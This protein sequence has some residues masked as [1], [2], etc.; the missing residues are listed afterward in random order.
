MKYLINFKERN[1]ALGKVIETPLVA[2]VSGVDGKVC[3]ASFEEFGETV[4]IVE[5]DEDFIQGYKPNIETVTVQELIDKGYARTI[6]QNDS[7]YAIEILD[8]CPYNI[9]EIS[10]FDEILTNSKQVSDAVGG[11]NTFIWRNLPEGWS[12]NDIADKYNNNTIM[13]KPLGGI[14][15]VDGDGPDFSSIDDM[16]V[17]FG[18]GADYQLIYAYPWGGFPNTRGR[19]LFGGT[20][21][22]SPKKFTASFEKGVSS[23]AQRLFQYMM[24]TEELTIDVKPGAVI[25]CHDF[26]GCFEGCNS[27]KKININ[28]EWRWNMNSTDRRASYYYMF[29]GCSKLVEIPLSNLSDDREYSCNMIT[30]IHNGDRGTNF[31]TETFEGCDS[32]KSIKPTIDATELITTDSVSFYTPLLEDVHFKGLNN[33]SWSF[34][35]SKTY[36]PNMN[37]ESIEYLL[38][39]IGDCGDNNYTV[40]FSSLH[41][42]EVSVD[43]INNAK[44]K[45]WNVDFSIPMSERAFTD[46][47]INANALIDYDIDEYSITIRKFKPNTWLMKKVPTVEEG[48]TMGDAV[49]KYIE[50]FE[51]ILSG[52]DENVGEDKAFN[53][54]KTNDDAGGYF[55]QGL[56][57]SAIWNMWGD[58]N[59]F[60]VTTYPW[61]CGVPGGDLKNPNGGWA[62]YGYSKDGFNDVYNSTNKAYKDSV[63]GLGF[64]LYTSSQVGDDGCITLETPV[65]IRIVIY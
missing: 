36:I 21:R 31:F 17:T 12:V 4:L 58:P 24:G 40:K 11:Y 15:G 51:V 22:N 8:T 53:W 60:V 42:D 13:T 27:L 41:R 20:G 30:P 10:D 18:E 26:S 3:Y 16:K 1:K 63:T 47:T 49:Y 62:R 48:S 37:V 43:S 29:K 9:V 56:V 57:M 14:F 46:W 65:V 28:G 2:T 34:V 19:N 52:F 50:N 32:L 39:N 45:G 25:S 55:A 5:K 38:N 61:D 59:R 35:S 54:Y 64:G 6:E 44:S 23:V 33:Q 7:G